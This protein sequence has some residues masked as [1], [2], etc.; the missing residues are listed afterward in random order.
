M[1]ARVHSAA[2][3]GVDAVLVDV[4]VDAS[5]GLPGCEIVGL[6][7]SAVRESKARVYAAIRNCHLE[8]PPRRL[9]INLAPADIRSDACRAALHR[10]SRLPLRGVLSKARRPFPQAS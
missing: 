10:E 6:P 7:D 9:T 1:L 2:L 8:L 4:E 5:L 3:M